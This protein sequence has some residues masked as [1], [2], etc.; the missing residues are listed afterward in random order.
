VLET[1]CV[2]GNG[3]ADSDKSKGIKDIGGIDDAA[4]I[5][6]LPDGTYLYQG[7]SYEDIIEFIG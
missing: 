2:K 5:K 7:R 6:T 4:T 3:M 1:R